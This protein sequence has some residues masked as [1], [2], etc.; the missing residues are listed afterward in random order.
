MRG[1]KL[2]VTIGESQ[3]FGGTA[4]GS[5]GLASADGGV[6]VSL[7]HAIH[8]CRPRELPRPDVRRSQASRAAATW[9]STS[10]DRGLGA[11][12]DQHAQRR[13]EPERP[14]GGALAG[15]NVEQWLRRLERRPLSGNGDFRSWT[16]AVRPVD[17]ERSRSCRGSR[18]RGRH[19]PDGPAVRHRA[20]G[21]APCRPANLTSKVSPR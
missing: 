2:D 8:R 14:H 7:A 10:K 20:G 13:R 18:L 15:V 21:Q 1:G 9:R 6:A 5:L 19:A 12:G 17:A 3:A 4:K 11:G 16:D